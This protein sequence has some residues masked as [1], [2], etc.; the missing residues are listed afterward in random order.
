MPVEKAT[1]P[2][3]V[4]ASVNVIFPLVVISP[5]VDTVPPPSCKNSPP[6]V[7]SPNA[8]MLSNPELV[9]FTS[10]ATPVFTLLLKVKFVPLRSRPSVAEVPRVCTG[11]VKV[12][13][14]DPAF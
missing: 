7:I 12:V 10:P 11:P 6:M 9:I 5:A 3:N 2:V 4:T 14:P 1:F 13:V 8:A